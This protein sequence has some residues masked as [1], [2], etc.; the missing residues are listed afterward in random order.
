[1]GRHAEAFAVFDEL[2]QGPVATRAGPEGG[3]GMQHFD[4]FVQVGVGL[5]ET[6]AETGEKMDHRSEI[7]EG[8]G[9]ALDQAIGR[10]QF[11]EVIGDEFVL[12]DLL[13][14]VGKV[15]DLVPRSGAGEGHRLEDTIARGEELFRRGA[16][17]A[18]AALAVAVAPE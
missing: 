6:D 9:P 15:V 2:P 8:A 17:K 18:G 7:E 10:Q 16:N 14:V 4:E 1:M 11:L 3:R 13:R 12:A 5:G